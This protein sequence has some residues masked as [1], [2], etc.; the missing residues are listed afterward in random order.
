[1]SADGRPPTVGQIKVDSAIPKIR[2]NK[3][4]W[5]GWGYHGAAFVVSDDLQT[6][7]FEGPG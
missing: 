1:M 4:K 5:N 2:Q 7:K 6:C 3:L